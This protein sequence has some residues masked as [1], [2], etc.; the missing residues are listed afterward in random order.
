MWS[1]P[2][3]DRGLPDED[4]DGLQPRLPPSR[5]ESFVL[6]VTLRYSC[7]ECKL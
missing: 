7:D 5:R 2:R 4:V 3:N 6:I 1:E